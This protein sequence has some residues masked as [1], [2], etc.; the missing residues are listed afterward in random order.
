MQL[1]SFHIGV[2]LLSMYICW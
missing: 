1:F 2:I